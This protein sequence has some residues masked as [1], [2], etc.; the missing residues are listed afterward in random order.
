LTIF[1]LKLIAQLKVTWNKK[2]A[3]GCEFDSLSK[4]RGLVKQA[5]DY[6]RN[7]LKES[8]KKILQQYLTYKRQ[9]QYYDE[10]ETSY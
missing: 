5:K 8:N 9:K 7:K 10:L 4:N 2:N 6:T 1:N 3:T